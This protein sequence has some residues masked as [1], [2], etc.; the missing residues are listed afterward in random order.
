VFAPYAE[1][2]VFFSDLSALYAMR[3]TFMK[4][5]P[6]QVRESNGY[7]VSIL[8][9]LKWVFKKYIKNLNVT[10]KHQ[11]LRKPVLQS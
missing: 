7:C 3:P 6:G 10:R 8:S 1:L 5:T 4:S 9:H 2:I 11:P